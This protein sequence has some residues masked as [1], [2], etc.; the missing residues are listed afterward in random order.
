MGLISLRKDLLFDDKSYK[1]KKTLSP[2]K[3]LRFK[4][5]KVQY[6]DKNSS[7]QLSKGNIH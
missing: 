7:I 2:T 4:Y 1:M 6:A 5:Q 3:I